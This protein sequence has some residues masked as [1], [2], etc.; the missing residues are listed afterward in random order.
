MTTTWSDPIAAHFPSLTPGDVHVWRAGLDLDA[1]ELERLRKILAP[2]ELARAG[3]FHFEKDRRHFIASRGILREILAR[4]LICGAERLK[5]RYSPYGKPRLAPETRGD[6][7]YF[8]LSHSHDL[9]LY[10]IS[11]FPEIGVDI[12]LVRGDF[13]CRELAQRFFSPSEINALHSLPESA[14]RLAFFSCWTRKE[15]FSKAQGKGLSIPLDEF[16]VSIG[17]GE[18]ASLLQAESDS[19]EVSG[20]VLK[21][22][23]PAQEYIAAVAVKAPHCQIR[24]WQWMQRQRSS[25]C[26]PAASVH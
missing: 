2:D 11:R 19:V 24:C 22:I 25:V 15:A 3:R 12:E 5:F 26:T 21:E 13:P 10:A 1:P 16:A 20:W 6:G 18:P 8:N 9:A 7:L 17:P 23:F 4:Y 14:R